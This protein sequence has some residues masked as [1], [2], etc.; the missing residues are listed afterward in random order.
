VIAT[1]SV[2]L[3]LFPRHLVADGGEGM[4]DTPANWGSFSNSYPVSGYERTSF[5][6]MVK[7]DSLD[8]VSYHYYPVDWGMSAGAAAA[9]GKAWIDG[10]QALAKTAGKVA[11]WGELGFQK[12]ASDATRAPIYDGW[13]A[14]FFSPANRGSIVMFWQLVPQSRGADDG[15]GVIIGRDP[16][17]VAAFEKYSQSRALR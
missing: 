12:G 16:L 7:L 2:T 6:A 10:H 17:T 5:T 11:Y 1:V 15:F 13:L 14:D 3:G 8:L 9:D 4:D